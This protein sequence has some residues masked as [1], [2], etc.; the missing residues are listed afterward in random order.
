MLSA[1]SKERGAPDLF[2]RPFVSQPALERAD[3]FKRLS[4]PGVPNDYNTRVPG[5]SDAP[6][7]RRFIAHGMSA[8][9]AKRTSGCRSGMADLDVLFQAGDISE[10]T[11]LVLASQ[12]QARHAGMWCFE[13]DMQLCCLHPR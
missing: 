11:F 7:A 3:D 12:Y 8:F 13:P 5:F 6:V 9:G 10:D 2:L 4:E 1:R